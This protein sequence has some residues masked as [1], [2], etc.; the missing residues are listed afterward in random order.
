MKLKSITAL[1]AIILACAW[2]S[3]AQTATRPKQP[4]WEYLIVSFGKVYFV[5]P[6]NDPEAKASGSSKLLSFSQA[7]IVIAQ[8]GIR[9]QRPMDTL[10]KF[11]WELV[12][13]VGAIGGDQEMLF[14]RPYDENRSKQEEELIKQE[15]EN[16]RKILEAERAK[17]SR[18][19]PATELVDLDEI[20]RIEARNANRKSQEDRLKASTASV[21]ALK[22]KSVLSD[23]SS[24][25]EIDVTGTYVIDGTSQ[26]LTDGNKYRSSAAKQLAETTLKS[27]MSAAGVKEDRYASGTTAFILG[28]VKVAVE[29]TIL[30]NGK[31]KVVASARSGGSW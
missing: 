1:S 31:E 28:K 7:G 11:G 25:T 20:D 8:E 18:V 10:G 24:A 19:A 22:V 29:V 14:K 12:G 15:G 16:L 23:A 17:T 21:P 27:I 13:V 30:H 9:T 2:S 3:M 26:L 4:Q 6:L 5:D